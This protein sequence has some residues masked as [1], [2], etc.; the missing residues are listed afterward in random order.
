[1]GTKKL[2]TAT[3]QRQIVEQALGLIAQNG[4]ERLRVAELGV[5]TGLVPSAVYRH[6]EG[7]DKIILAVLDFVGDRLSQ[8]V[9]S[10]RQE[11][12]DPLDQLRRLFYRHLKLLQENP[13]IPSVI[14]AGAVF[15]EGTPN[16]DKVREIIEGYLAK[17]AEI[18]RVGQE[19][20]RIGSDHDPETL[21]LMFLGLILPIVV[22]SRVAR[23]E[24]DWDSHAQKAWKVF[25]ESMAAPV[26]P[27][28]PTTRSGDGRLIRR[29][30]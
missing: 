7:K 21:S 28:E 23:K 4:L 13:G 19:Y 24:V 14:F 30:G 2:D 11:A 12:S 16:R 3:R 1:M 26:D 6:F 10:A 9:Q 29:K 22:L 18:I 25:S 15:S 8:N 27:A 17:V 20:G 5:R